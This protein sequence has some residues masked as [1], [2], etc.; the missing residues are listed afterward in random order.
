[1]PTVWLEFPGG[2]DLIAV[3]DAE[4]EDI[5]LEHCQHEDECKVYCYSKCCPLGLVETRK[6]Q[7]LQKQQV[8]LRKQQE[9]LIKRHN[10][11]VKAFIIGNACVHASLS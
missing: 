4:A 2:V 8:E 9:E 7:E 1:M 3:D 5:C 11:R 6:L 10:A